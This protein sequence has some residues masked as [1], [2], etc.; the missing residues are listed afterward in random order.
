MSDRREERMWGKS[1]SN[2]NGWKLPKFYKCHKS[3][4]LK[5]LIQRKSVSRHSIYKFLKIK[6]KK[7]WKQAERNDALI[8]YMQIIIQITVDFS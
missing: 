2:N 5:W 8:T 4:D 6:D 3:T 7:Y 1:I